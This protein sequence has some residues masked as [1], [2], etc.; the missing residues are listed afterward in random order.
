MEKADD[1]FYNPFMTWEKK[2]V[3]FTNAE[4]VKD[5]GDNRTVG[6]D[7]DSIISTKGRRGH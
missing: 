7:T 2:D 3:M 5:L 6:S 1:N 4:A